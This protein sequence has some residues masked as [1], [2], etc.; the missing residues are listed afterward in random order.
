MPKG[1][2]PEQGAAGEG[3]DQGEQQELQGRR[4]MGARDRRRQM[5]RGVGFGR[6]D[7]GMWHH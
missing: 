4:Q 2:G 1:A 6:G 7:E 5:A 3:R